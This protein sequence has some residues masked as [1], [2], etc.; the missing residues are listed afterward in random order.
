MAKSSQHSMSLRKWVLDIPAVPKPDR[1]FNKCM[2]RD[3]SRG[4]PASNKVLEYC[5]A[6]ASQGADRVIQVSA[7]WSAKNAQRDLVSALGW[8]AKAPEVKWIMIPMG[9]KMR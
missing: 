5:N 4:E 8:P 9:P 2:R 1:P 7:K 6:A 3:W